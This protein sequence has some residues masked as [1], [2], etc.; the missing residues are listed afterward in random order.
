MQTSSPSSQ[1]C[2]L[3]DLLHLH[4]CVAASWPSPSVA[5]SRHVAQCTELDECCQTCTLGDEW[6][7]AVRPSQTVH[8]YWKTSLMLSTS[9]VL[10]SV[11]T[12]CA[13]IYVEPAAL[14]DNLWPA[15]RHGSVRLWRC[16]GWRLNLFV[17]GY[18][19][20]CSEWIF[21]S[22]CLRPL[23]KMTTITWQPLA[24]TWQ[25]R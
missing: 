24:V 7:L 20:D 8:S 5:A 17:Q 9:A 3:R 6:L 16:S 14:A 22:T 23:A 25:V 4:V 2:S 21:L 10:K 13:A 18:R 11:V 12:I 19:L 15:H 1:A